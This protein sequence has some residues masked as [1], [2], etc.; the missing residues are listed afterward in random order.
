MALSDDIRNYIAANGRPTVAVAEAPD[1]LIVAE[2]HAR[3]AQPADI[4]LLARHRR[5]MFEEMA[6][7][8]GAPHP[9]DM[10]ERVEREYAALLAPALG[11]SH[12]GFLIDDDAAAC[13]IAS[14][15]LWYAP[16]LPHPRYPQ[17]TLAYLHSVWT[18]APYRGRGYARA[19]TQAAI[20]HAR[21]RGHTR[22]VLHAS[23]AGRPIYEGLGFA[24]SNEMALPLS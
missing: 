10:L 20:A 22:L 1:V 19:I 4:P 5:N 23:E 8:A 13:G 21:E 16:W 2:I 12:I 14:G 6:R 15:T 9:L 3:L 11:G 7:L 17:G 24:A 18:D